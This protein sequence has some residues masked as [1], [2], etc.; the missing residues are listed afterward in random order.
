MQI[1]SNKY[2]EKWPKLDKIIFLK[3]VYV[4][5]LNKIL[6]KK[7]KYRTNKPLGVVSTYPGDQLNVRFYLQAILN[8][9]IFNFNSKLRDF[10]SC[11]SLHMKVASTV[12]VKKVDV[13]Y[14]KTHYTEK[15]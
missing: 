13:S 4:Q 3:C 9:A 2:K 6:K 11:L 10:I 8:L 5:N 7:S 15:I 12:S 14:K 1:D